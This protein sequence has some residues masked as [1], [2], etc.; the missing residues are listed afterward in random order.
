MG[1]QGSI[2]VFLYEFDCIPE[3]IGFSVNAVICPVTG[4]IGENEQAYMHARFANHRENPSLRVLCN[5]ISQNAADLFDSR[6]I[7]RYRAP[8]LGRV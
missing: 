4:D 7:N 5:S 1:H 3:R 6:S 8:H 2:P